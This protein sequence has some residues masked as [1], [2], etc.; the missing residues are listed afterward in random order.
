[1]KKTL[2]EQ[3]QLLY[4]IICDTVIPEKEKGNAIHSTKRKSL[5]KK[6]AEMIIIMSQEGHSLEERKS[7]LKKEDKK[8]GNYA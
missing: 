2:E 4:G 7:H 1:M 8:E 3:K 6:K 5:R